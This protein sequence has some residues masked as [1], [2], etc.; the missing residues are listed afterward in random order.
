MRLLR[1]WSQPVHK[2]AGIAEVSPAAEQKWLAP[3]LPEAK[4]G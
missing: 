4:A 2:D 3:L 1:K